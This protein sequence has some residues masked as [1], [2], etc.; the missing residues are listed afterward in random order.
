MRESSVTVPTIAAILPV[1]LSFM[2]FA[3]LESESG[4]RLI[5]DMNRRFNTVLL[6]SESVRRAKKRYSF[7]SRRRY[8]FS[9][10]GAVRCLTLLRP[11]ASMSIP[12]DTKRGGEREGREAEGRD[13]SVSVVS[14]EARK[15]DGRDKP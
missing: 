8:T 15:K 5:L 3:S 10:L 12:C 14:R 1:P 2:N 11:P 7:T 9:D 4:G 6:K 13:R